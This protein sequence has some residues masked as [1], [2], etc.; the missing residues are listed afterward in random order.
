VTIGYQGEPHSYSF[1]AAGE[2]FPGGDRIGFA[3]FQAA[4]DALQGGDVERLVVPIENSTTGSILPV[5]DRLLGN[6]LH[7]TGEHLVEVQHALLAHP[8]A[9]L[10]TIERVHSHPEAL[11]QAQGTI[12][13]HGW[14]AHPEHDTA[15]AVRLVA[16]RGDPR[17][18]CLAHVDAAA[19]HGLIVLAENMVDRDHNTTRFVVLEPGPATVPDDGDKTSVAFETRHHPGA[20]A[21]A[22]TEL[23]LRGANLTR[24]ESRPSEEAW[25]YR[26]FVDLQHP[27]GKAGWDAIFEPAPATLAFLHHLGTYRA[28]L[29]LS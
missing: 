27:P 22:L 3:S 10:E 16:E 2:L 11:T 15:G 14:D 21:L 12:A 13:R 23:G 9:T 26:M 17:E 8:G 4:F 24:I 5:L 19:P 6:D 20:L 29:P 7:I 1:R 18:A 28:A 25:R